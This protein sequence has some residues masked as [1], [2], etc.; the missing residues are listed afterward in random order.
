MRTSCSLL[1][2]YNEPQYLGEE[3]KIMFLFPQMKRICCCGVLLLI[4]DVVCTAVSIIKKI[5]ELLLK[6]V[7]MIQ[8]TVICDITLLLKSRLT[9]LHHLSQIHIIHYICIHND[10]TIACAFPQS[11]FVLS[12]FV[13]R[14][15]WQTLVY[16]KESDLLPYC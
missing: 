2:T 16:H 4:N 3:L 6:K 11:G 5:I 13:P 1:I 10:V 7:I 8:N 14:N 9:L 15:L 12:K